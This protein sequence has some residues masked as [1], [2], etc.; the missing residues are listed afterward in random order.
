MNA[1]RLLA[2]CERMSARE[3]RLASVV[4][5]LACVLLVWLVLAPGFRALADRW[6]SVSA[7][8]ETLAST[9]R[10]LARQERELARYGEQL[11]KLEWEVPRTQRA[12]AFGSE[13][14]ALAREAG[15]TFTYTGK[16]ERERLKD[17]DLVEYYIEVDCR[18]DMRSLVVFLKALEE[19]PRLYVVRG[20]TVQRALPPDWRPRVSLG[21]SA[22][23]REGDEG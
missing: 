17:S 8:S 15:V 11:A 10:L 7:L 21:I 18:P 6:S 12:L 3:R 13:V 2:L 1:E 9:K 4:A 22:L 5:A 23:V 20:M 16:V 19:A 14:T